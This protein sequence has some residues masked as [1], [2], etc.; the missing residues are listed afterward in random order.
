MT[1]VNTSSWIEQLS[2][3]GDGGIRN[4]VESLLIAVEAPW[5]PFVELKLWNGARGD[6]ELSALRRTANTRVSLEIDGEV[7]ALTCRNAHLC[8]EHGI[9]APASDIIVTACA[10]RHGVGLEHN[11][12]HFELI[13]SVITAALHRNVHHR[14]RRAGPLPRCDAPVCS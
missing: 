11:D 3:G 1:F 14:G 4:R 13:D 7:W 9:S 6:R 8:R 2:A 12:R 10:R 5:C